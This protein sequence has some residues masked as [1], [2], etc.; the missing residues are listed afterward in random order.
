MLEAALLLQ[1]HGFEGLGVAQE[2]PPLRDLARAHPRDIGGLVLDAR[3][4][5][6]ADVGGGAERQHAV[7]ECAD[8]GLLVAVVVPGLEEVSPCAPNPVETS[9]A[10]SLDHVSGQ[11]E[12]DR[13]IEAIEPP[14]EVPP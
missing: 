6:L 13:R 3:T 11:K 7:V 10:P 1:P 14:V 9:I 5:A 12:L 4:A 2:R 8:V